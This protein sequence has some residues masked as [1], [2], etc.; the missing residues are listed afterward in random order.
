MKIRNLLLIGLIPILFFV[1]SCSFFPTMSDED[2]N[3]AQ[4]DA[5]L[6]QA[7][8]PGLEAAMAVYKMPKG[9]KTFDPSWTQANET[10]PSGTPEEYYTTYYNADN[11]YA[12][13]P[14]TGYLTD[15]YRTQG[16]EAYLEISKTTDGWGDY[17]VS[18]YIYP[19][20]SPSVKYTLEKYRVAS[21][22]WDLVDNTGTKDPV[23]Y[24]GPIQTYYFDGRV[25]KR[26]V[27]WTRYVD[28]KIYPATEFSIPEDPADLTIPSSDDFS[29]YKDTTLAK[30]TAGGGQYSSYT[31][32][33][34]PATSDSGNIATTAKEYYSELSNGY[35]YSKSYVKDDLSN[36]ISNTTTMTTREY[37][38]DASGNKKIRSK[39]TGDF[40]YGSF[41]WTTTTTEKV[42]ITVDAGVVTYNS[43]VAKTTTGDIISTTTTVISLIE[44]AANSN[45]FTGIERITLGEKTYSYA[46]T[47]DPKS[48][49]QIT[50]NNGTDVSYLITLAQTNPVIEIILARKARFT[51]RLIGGILKGKYIRFSKQA[52][53]ILSRMFLKLT[54]GG[55]TR[56]K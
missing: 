56:V 50:D 11:G 28:E 46:V 16:N 21:G 41:S 14:E 43:T 4:S 18:L 49:L 24:D 7:M 25:E 5:E 27:K 34:I 3:V 55:K 42:D 13:Y 36:T 37:S 12:R 33:S 35:K 26:T 53:V 15:F 44:T 54:S 2:L 32:S 31:E 6:I 22:S 23:A 9:T 39:S 17:A 48:G 38:E 29:S 52:D 1:F 47:L 20:L 8:I 45:S 51:G 19:T 30:T 40:K 10:I